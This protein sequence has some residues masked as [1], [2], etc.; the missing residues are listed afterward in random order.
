MSRLRLPVSLI[1]AV[2]SSLIISA[3]AISTILQE[4]KRKK[5]PAATAY[6]YTATAASSPAVQ[7]KRKL[8]TIGFRGCS[9]EEAT[10]INAAGKPVYDAT[11]TTGKKMLGSG[12]Y[13]ADRLEN[14]F[15]EP[16][17]HDWICVVKARRDCIQDTPKV[18]LAKMV[19][20][21]REGQG[22]AD[23][24]ISHDDGLIDEYIR[25]M[26]DGAVDPARTLRLGI[27]HKGSVSPRLLVTPALV[28]EDGLGLWARC[29]KH[30]DLAGLADENFDPGFVTDYGGVPWDR[31]VFRAAPMEGLYEELV[32]LGLVS[33]LE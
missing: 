28:E 16:G 15:K 30:D 24:R 27:G 5:P 21:W 1:T 14:A 8:I 31:P 2:A 19:R 26:G 23:V 7:H 25:F 11:K 18:W 29:L 22:E 12:I 17:T 9:E 13:L 32:S 10:A 33:S 20:P 6:S 4:R 3:Y